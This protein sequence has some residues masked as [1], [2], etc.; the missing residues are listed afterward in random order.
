M[1]AP[2][3]GF[4]K[5]SFK[6]F[7]GSYEPTL[8]VNSGGTAFAFSVAVS[9]PLDFDRSVL[10]I[11]PCLGTG[12]WLTQEGHSLHDDLTQWEITF[13]VPQGKAF[14]VSAFAEDDLGHV[15]PRPHVVKFPGTIFT[16]TTAAN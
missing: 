6:L 2:A 10:R 5:F 16:P 12:H 3:D 7:R 15:E 8:H 1:E 4:P 14:T 9:W 13:A 11:P